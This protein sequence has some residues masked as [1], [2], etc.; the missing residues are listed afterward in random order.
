MGWLKNRAIT[1][2][3]TSTTLFCPNDAVNRL[4]MAAFMNRLGTAMTPV[5][6]R[7]DDAPGSIDLDANPVVC[8]TGTSLAEEFPRIALRGRVD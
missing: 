7:V 3:C 5:Q 4:Q 8:Q 6:L 2:G 1:L